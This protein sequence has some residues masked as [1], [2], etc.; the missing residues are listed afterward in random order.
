MVIFYAP[1]EFLQAA[2]AALEAQSARRD[3]DNAPPPSEDANT[4][5]RP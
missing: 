1:R 3:D 4:T 5:E 2:Y